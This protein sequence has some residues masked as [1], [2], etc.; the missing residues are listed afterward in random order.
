MVLHS[1]L[2]VA[3]LLG[4]ATGSFSDGPIGY[5]DEAYSVKV[6]GAAFSGLALNST[7]TMDGVK[8]KGFRYLLLTLQYTFNA[9]TAVTMTCQTS[10]DNSTW[11]DI[12]VLNLTAP[13]TAVSA[14]MVWSYTVGAASHNWVWAVPVRGVYMRCSF[15]GTGANA[16]DLLTVSARAGYY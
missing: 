13:P 11:A 10:E 2:L 6:S 12:H 8:V 14:P 5:K 4:D 15:S 9:A 16:S 3:A 1:V 7:Q